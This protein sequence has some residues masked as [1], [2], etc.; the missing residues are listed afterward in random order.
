MMKATRARVTFMMQVTPIETPTDPATGPVDL[1]PPPTA[2]EATAAPPA[3]APA[4]GVP[5]AVFA[6]TVTGAFIVALDLSIVNVAFVSMHE[7]FPGTPATTLSWV[8]TAYSVVFGALLLGAGRIADRSGRRRAFLRGLAVFAVGSAIC[9]AAPAVEVLIAGRVVQAVGAALLMPA[10]LA[11]LLAATP[12]PARPRA[13]AMWGGIAALAVA[14]GPSLGSVLIS[15]GGWRWAFLVNLPVT[16]VA[17]VAAARY[18]RESVVGGPAPDLLGI[19]M[20]SVAIAALALGIT[21]GQPW[22]WTSPAVLASFATAAALIPLTV[23]RARHHP[24]PAVD[25]RVFESRTATL[26]NAATLAY[27]TGF[28]AMLLA[29]VLFLTTVWGFTTLQAGLAITPGPLLVAALSSTTGRWATRSGYRIVLVLGGLIFAAGTLALA[30]L[31]T[32]E[33]AYLSRWLPISLV[34]GLGVALTFPVLSAAAVAGLPADRFGAGGATN[35]TARQL[36]AVLGV[37]L[38]VAI[39]GTPAGP[40][41]ALGRFQWVWVMTTVAAA[42]SA[43]ISLGQRRPAAGAA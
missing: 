17:G 7:S 14:L 6:L 37:A 19:V 13:V 1:L 36:G 34:I 33:P 9:G 3:P 29:N 16:V 2:P 24:A 23:V 35:Q 20:V 28:F 38:L 41:D 22:G 31:I 26:A 10:S 30:T 11:L 32:T 8:L 18:A 27:A 12:L 39:L 5:R 21:Q 43:A 4:A 15:A 40:A 25:L 42:L